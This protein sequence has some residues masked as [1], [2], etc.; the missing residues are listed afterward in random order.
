[1]TIGAGAHS[2]SVIVADTGHHRVCIWHT[3]RSTT[4]NYY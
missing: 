3:V 4:S 1:V 2:N